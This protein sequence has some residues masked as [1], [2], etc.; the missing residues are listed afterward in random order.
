M[1]LPCKT[2]IFLFFKRSYNWNSNM[3]TMKSGNRVIGLTYQK[4]F[5][6]SSGVKYMPTTI[7][8]ATIPKTESK[9]L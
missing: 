2:V 3:P 7:S 8:I 9:Y 5:I 1:I 4:P 6:S